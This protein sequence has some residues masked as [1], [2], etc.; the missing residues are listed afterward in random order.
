MTD[1]ELLEYCGGMVRHCFGCATVDVDKNQ[2]IFEVRIDDR[3]FLVCSIN[4]HLFGYCNP[5]EVPKFSAELAE[6]KKFP[7][8]P[9]IKV[10]PPND[11]EIQKPTDED[12]QL[13]ADTLEK[14]TSD[15]YN[16]ISN[17]DFIEE[18]RVR[19]NVVMNGLGGNPSIE[20][21]K[22]AMLDV[23]KETIDDQEARRL[24]KNAKERRDYEASL[25]SRAQQERD[26]QMLR[27]GMELGNE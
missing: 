14:M 6:N 24:L 8:H 25:P 3:V 11:H 4:G 19:T 17:P 13:L 20:D 2:F 12:R 15:F 7:G 27:L 1:K 16:R 9:T 10:Y 26:Y 22:K 5:D 21:V 23:F 18:D